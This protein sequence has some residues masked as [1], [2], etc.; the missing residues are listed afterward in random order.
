MAESM[1]GLKRTHRCT[2]VSSADIGST[3][4]VMGW[5]A[6]RRNL[7]SLIFVDLR[8]R[9]GLLQILFDEN[10]IGKEGFD[11]LP[12][13]KGKCDTVTMMAYGFDPYLS[14]WSPYHGAMY[15]VTD[16]V[17]K[18]VAAG[19]DYSKIRFTYQEYFRRMTE[20]PS[21]WSQPFAALLGAYEAQIGLG[22]PS[23]GGKDSMSGTFE[24]ID[25]PPTLC[26]F[27]ID[28]AKEQDIITP[29]LKKA[30][31]ILVRFDIERDKYDLPVF[32]QIKELY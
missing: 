29:E 14:K 17:A 19:G 28:V 3:V 32:S 25:V 4:T 16:S 10:I 20:D 13:L 11:K 6:K 12:V 22:L 2:E 21:R 27:A 5:V 24:H 18:I 31:N 7:G 9:S 26:S 15:A 30:G 1:V 8:D 23:I